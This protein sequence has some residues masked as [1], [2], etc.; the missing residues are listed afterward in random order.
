M[1]ETRNTTRL[2]NPA[3]TVHHVGVAQIYKNLFA[4]LKDIAT[5]V[6]KMGS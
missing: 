1:K 4:I 5:P 3:Y 2:V 6:D